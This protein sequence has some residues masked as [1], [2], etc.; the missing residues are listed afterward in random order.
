MTTDITQRLSEIKERWPV[1]DSDEREA[2]QDIRYLLAQFER[3]SADYKTC[4]AKFWD[5]QQ[6][7]ADVNNQFTDLQS[8][9]DRSKDE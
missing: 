4:S 1:T 6:R 3:L 8:R 7:Y 5:L 9:Q 2:T